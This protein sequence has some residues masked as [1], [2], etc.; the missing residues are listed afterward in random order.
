MAAAREA[1]DVELLD[2]LEALPHEP[3]G[4]DVWRIVR[5]GRDPL[6]SYPS[7]VRWDPLGGFDVLYT[8]LD[9]D[10]AHAE[11]FFHLNRAPVFPSR[12]VYYL[13]TIRIQTRR[14]L[15]LADMS[16]LAGLKVDTARYS[17]LEYSQTQ[18]IG[19]AAHFLGF[20]GLIVPSARWQGLNL[21]LFMDRLDPDDELAVSPCEPVDWQAWRNKSNSP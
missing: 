8:A 18:A 21:I 7:G 12:T 5:E 1:R 9:P 20:D 16:A 17:A 13:Y 4:G 11:I 2:A 15:R 3:F 6:L 10:G 14:T 19:D